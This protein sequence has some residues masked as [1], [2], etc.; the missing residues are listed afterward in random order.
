LGPAQGRKIPIA[1]DPA[2]PT[3]LVRL[4][5]CQVHQV[6]RLFESGSCPGKHFPSKIGN[7]DAARLSSIED[8]LS[9]SLFRVSQGR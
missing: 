4:T 6:I 9:L 7:P 5:V 8:A 1:S 3:Q 2:G